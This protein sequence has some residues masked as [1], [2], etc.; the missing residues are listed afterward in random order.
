MFA[1][2]QANGR[3][4]LIS[5]G[6]SRKLKNLS[7]GP[8]PVIVLRAMISRINPPEELRALATAAILS[9]DG[10]YYHSADQLQ[11]SFEEIHSQLN[12]DPYSTIKTILFWT[13]LFA[14]SILFYSWV[15]RLFPH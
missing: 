10:K 2:S 5:I 3:Q 4:Q 6:S 11:G 13:V 14:L 7:K 1:T 9:K 8:S 12:R 15:Q